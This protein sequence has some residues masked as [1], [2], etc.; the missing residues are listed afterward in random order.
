RNLLVVFSEKFGIINNVINNIGT[1]IVSISS[2][3]LLLELFGYVNYTRK[4]M[5]EVLCED[6]VIKVLNIVRK[7]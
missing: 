1:L 2:G 5:C 4:R 3:S 6:E 7:K